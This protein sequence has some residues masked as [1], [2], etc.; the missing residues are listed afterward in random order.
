MCTHTYIHTHAHIHIQYDCNPDLGGKGQPSSNTK[1]VS[2]EETKD[3]D[4][5]N[6]WNE[7]IDKKAMSMTIVQENKGDT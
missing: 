7:D 5:L 6:K 3:D 2:K 1:Y 4:T